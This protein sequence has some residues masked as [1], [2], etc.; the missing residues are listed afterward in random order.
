MPWFELIPNS[1]NRELCIQN[2]V[3]T[4]SHGVIT[5]FFDARATT[6]KGA[7][8]FPRGLV[9]S[10][11][12]RQRAS[13]TVLRTGPGA[14]DDS[15]RSRLRVDAVEKVSAT[16]TTRNNGIAQAGFLNRSCAFDARLESI[17]LGDPLKIFFRQYRSRREDLTVRKS[18]P[19][20]PHKRKSALNSNTSG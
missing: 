13:S 10:W 20:N 3:S 16:L 12:T 17:L 4:V 11:H 2:F 6:V 1:A 18:L 8:A 19:L 7:P 5:A 14:L 9:W 15:P